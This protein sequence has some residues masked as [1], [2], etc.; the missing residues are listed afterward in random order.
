MGERAEIG[1]L[2]ENFD[3]CTS[4]QK[5]RVFDENGGL[6]GSDPQCTFCVQDKMGRVQSKHVKIAY[7]ENFFTIAP[8]GDCAVFYNQSFSKMQGG[9]DTAI[10]MGDVFKIGD[11][12]FRFVDAKSAEQIL[13]E[14]KEQLQDIEK[15]KE[16]DELVLKPRGQVSVNFNEKENI[17]ELI[18]GKDNYAFIEER[19][20]DSFLRQTEKKDPLKFDYENILKSLQKAF[21]DLQTQ[22]RSVKLNEN[23]TDL[24]IK[25]LESIMANIPLVKSTKLVNT[26]VLSLIA[27]EL[28][29]P[30]FEEM[31]EDVFIKYLKIAIQG[32]IK[33]DKVLFENLVMKALQRYIKDMGE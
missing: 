9:Y 17:K 12:E 30:I 2:I 6:I 29:S 27:K 25:D 13:T 8:V 19:I 26:I 10:N 23:Y 16:L 15:H 1:I 7:E 32:N 18:E 21:K 31:E 20:D 24:N 14:G 33:E 11:V 22:Q 4:Q 5:A 3:N 28:Y